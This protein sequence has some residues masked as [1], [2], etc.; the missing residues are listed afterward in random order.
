MF[1]IFSN[2]TF[3]SPYLFL[4]NWQQRWMHLMMKPQEAARAWGGWWGGSRCIFALLK[5]CG[6]DNGEGFSDFKKQPPSEIRKGK[7]VFWGFA[8]P[9]SQNKTRAPWRSRGWEG[10]MRHI[11]G[12]TGLGLAGES[13]LTLSVGL[14]ILLSL[15][16]RSLSGPVVKEQEGAA[17]WK[18]KGG[19]EARLFWHGE[20]SHTTHIFIS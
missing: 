4:C 9:S 17:G 1:A 8:E 13:Q 15:P 11:R 18:V 7:L 6:W 2:N 5:G 14:L 20:R 10:R 16:E 19:F 12:P 3:F